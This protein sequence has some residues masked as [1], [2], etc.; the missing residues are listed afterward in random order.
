MSKKYE[1]KIESLKEHKQD[2]KHKHQPTKKE[3]ILEIE[4]LMNKRRHIKTS[5]KNWRRVKKFGNAQLS[6][7]LRVKWY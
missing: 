6:C 7:L 5:K 1:H 2:K 4:N 3:A